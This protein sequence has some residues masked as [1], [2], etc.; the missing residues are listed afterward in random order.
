[1]RRHARR[2]SVSRGPRS[3]EGLRGFFDR[4]R[5]QKIERF[6]DEYY[7]RA[8]R[9]E[10]H[11][12]FCRLVYGRDLCQHGMLDMKQLDRLLEIASLQADRVVLEL[13]CGAGF[14]AEQVSERTRSRVVGVD[15]SSAAIEQARARV[16]RE[17]KTRLTFETK[18]IEK[19]DYP[20]RSFDAA[21]SIDTLYYVDDVENVVRR[22]ARALKPGG[23]M[24]V[25]YNVHPD[26][27]QASDPASASP[28]GL[29][30]DR[31]NLPYRTVDFT[32]ENREHWELRREVLSQLH[33]KFQEEDNL[34]LY[35]TR[36]DEYSEGF[37]DYHRFLYV[38]EPAITAGESAP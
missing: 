38:V 31:L 24:Y 8:Q 36:M 37:G 2:D 34:F 30:L 35:D 12:E 11:S 21:I 20:E 14:I 3:E 25:F 15:I 17:G 32:Q 6:Y 5:T 28:L 7:E 23:A 18:D 9:S 10:A 4:A 33:E 22:T 29:A 19:L 16:E 27:G 26:V 13:G 1:M